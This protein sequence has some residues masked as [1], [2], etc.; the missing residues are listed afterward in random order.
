MIYFLIPLRSAKTSN[1]WAAVEK[2]F[3]NTLASVFN[4]EDQDF[5]VIVACHEKPQLEHAY[6]NRLEFLIA[7]F[8]PPMMTSQHLTDK[9][10]KKRMLVNRAQQMDAEYIMF[11]DADDYISNRISGWIKGRSHPTGWFFKTGYEYNSGENTIRVTPN[12]NHI[13]GTSAI[14][15]ISSLTEPVDTSFT[16]YVRKDEYLFDFGHNEWLNILDLQ[17]KPHLD[18]IPFKGAIYVL[19]TGENWTNAAGQR[20]GSFRKL[21]RK[22]VPGL[23]PGKALRKE[24]ALNV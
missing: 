2:L 5:R 24:F 14:L 8:P 3:N 9:F 23:K 16:D 4:Q 20:I 18:A 21:Y 17:K 15:N 6:G 7:E 13:C 19:N 11:V 12:F 22:L 10:Y 1:N